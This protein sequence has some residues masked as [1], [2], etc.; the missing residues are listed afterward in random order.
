MACEACKK[1]KDI[2]DLSRPYVV[3]TCKTCG[4]KIKLRTPGAHGI[5]FKINEGDQFIMPAEFLTMSANPLKGTGQFTS[6][7]LSWFAEM[8]FG[9]DLAKKDSRKDFPASLR[10]IMESN[11]NFFK[12]AKY[13]EG[14]DLHALANE[15]EVFKR[16]NANQK[17][18]EWFGYM[19]AGFC[20]MALMAIEEG[21]ASDAAWATASAERFRALAIFKSNFEEVVFMGHSSR[22]LV[23][24]IRTWDANKENDDEGYWQVKLGEHAYAISQL[25]SVPV[26]LIQGRAHVGG[27]SVDGKDARFLD[28][29][30][31]GGNANDAILVEI[32]TPKTRLLG[33]RYRKNVFPP[34]KDLGGAVVQVNDY[35]HTL[36]EN[37]RL[38]EK[39]GVNTFNPRRVVIIGN[40]ENE[41]TDTRKKA[42]FELFR[43]SLAGVDVITFDEFFKKVEHLAKLFNLVRNSAPSPASDLRRRH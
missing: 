25:F 10:A 21:N 7:G 4:R 1:L 33:S 24:L 23:E 8:V 40:Y 37:I 38:T 5:G 28:F 32:K 29:M 17:T 9:V 11:E 15:E 27:M 34:S 13:L 26:T 6:Y 19:A 36:R 41:L 22:R 16:I 43:T 12:G 3:R 39:A 30:F 18:V 14:L 2:A 31:S 20:F 35:C 42:S